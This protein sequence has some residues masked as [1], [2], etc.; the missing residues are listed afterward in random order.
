MQES[1]GR[2]NALE[3][4]GGCA[5]PA[6]ANPHLAALPYRLRRTHA[7]SLSPSCDTHT[8]RPASP[9]GTASHTTD[10][11]YS[12]SIRMVEGRRLYAA[13]AVVMVAI[14]TAA[15]PPVWP[16]R[17]ADSQHTGRSIYG[18][19][20][21]GQFAWARSTTNAVKSSPA[22]G[23]NG[24]V[25][26]GS[27]DANLYAINQTTG[28]IIWK[29]PTGGAVDVSSPAISS[30]GSLVFFGCLDFKVRADVHSLRLPDYPTV[31]ATQRP[32]W[33]V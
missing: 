3:S 1:M 21:V 25:Y 18:A 30:D 12:S 32:R 8:C 27:S 22:L 5:T 10:L 20:R 17:G 33:H 31:A 9:S 14:A 26:V 6:R 19:T 24:V 28:T 15:S 16:E 23:S 13:V 29:T 4:G 11:I 2:R 7:C